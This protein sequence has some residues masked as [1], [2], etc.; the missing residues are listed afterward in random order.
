MDNGLL[1]K[2]WVEIETNLSGLKSGL[3]EAKTIAAKEL[4]EAGKAGGKSLDDSLSGAMNS[5]VAKGSSQFGSMGKSVLSVL[6]PSG[7]AVVGAV[8]GIALVAGA[9]VGLIK[10]L[11]SLEGWAKEERI[12]SVFKNLAISIGTTADVL[13]NRLN[14]ALAG[15]VE[16]SIFK[17]QAIKGIFYNLSGDML[18]KIAESARLA[19]KIIGEDT[20]TILTALTTAIGTGMPRLLNQLRIL[21]YDELRQVQKLMSEGWIQQAELIDIINNKLKY[22]NESARQGNVDNLDKIQ[23]MKTAV[24]ALGDAW[25]KRILDVLIQAQPI[26]IKILELTTKILTPSPAEVDR[27]SRIAFGKT[28]EAEAI[29][30]AT[31]TK[32]GQG[33]EEAYKNWVEMNKLA[34][35]K[36]AMEPKYIDPLVAQREL[37]RVRELNS[38]AQAKLSL[39]TLELNK[40][41]ELEDLR[42]RELIGGVDRLA[43]LELERGY[44]EKKLLAQKNI[45]EQELGKLNRNKKEH[46]DAIVGLEYQLRGIEIART[47]NNELFKKKALNETTAQQEKS[48]LG[49]IESENIAILENYKEWEKIQEDKNNKQNAMYDQF[50]KNEE[51][52]FDSEAIA[53]E[54]NWQVLLRNAQVLEDTKWQDIINKKLLDEA[55]LVTNIAEQRE[56]IRA[57]GLMG[58]ISPG[59]AAKEQIP[60]I[61]QQIDHY[62]KLLDTVGENKLLAEQY[63]QKLI[64]LG[65]TM[66]DQQVVIREYNGTLGEGAQKAFRAFKDSANSD[67]KAGAEITTGALTSFGDE[68]ARA[69]TDFAMGTKTAGEAFN[70]FAKNFASNIMNMIMKIYMYRAAAA[71][72]G[73]MT[74]PSSES[75]GAYT[76]T[77]AE[78]AA[79]Y[80]HLGGTIGETV[81]PTRSVS[82]YLF[83][84][85]PR[86]H[87]GL[88]S[89]EF[90]AILQRGEKVTP[91]GSGNGVTPITVNVLNQSSA[92][93]EGKQKGQPYFDGK[94]VIVNIVLEDLAQGGQLYSAMKGISSRN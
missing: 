77:G 33:Y 38:I 90:P 37:E 58:E 59:D 45:T 36:A 25:S 71:A 78:V 89:D 21:T 13:E 12:N 14:K 31:G 88:A 4:G 41:L 91:K 63:K 57:A 23:Q 54:N 68:G 7:T 53:L 83:D 43:Q 6:G 92:K 42:G 34:K 16:D 85:A 55:R 52:L 61:Q 35:D 81:L 22:V 79:G 80:G 32:R 65:A 17:A 3:A 66:T 39:S 11:E 64:E 50:R 20:A 48:R 46:E 72:V 44:N 56:R 9:V 30:G 18:V 75:Y 47:A 67:F 84:Y 5:L 28:P 76:P 60:I 69:F 19:S 40:S 73:W 8:G 82:P 70:D 26:L 15:T 94:S 87:S 74:G 24:D 93:V 62:K 86:L 2:I 29:L 10:A 51:A 27:E 1:G 49:L